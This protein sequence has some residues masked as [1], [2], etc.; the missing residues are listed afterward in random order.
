M[1]ETDNITK[2]ILQKYLHLT[3]AS[4]IRKGQNKFI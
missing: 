4:K 2:N 3:F 1:K